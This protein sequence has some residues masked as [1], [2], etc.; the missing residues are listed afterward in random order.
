[1]VGD[2]RRFVSEGTLIQLTVVVVRSIPVVSMVR[3]IRV[4]VVVWVL[5][6]VLV[7]VVLV[8]S[9]GGCV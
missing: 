1:M 5:V 4:R 3:R 2:R 9:R 6:R 7:V 8:I